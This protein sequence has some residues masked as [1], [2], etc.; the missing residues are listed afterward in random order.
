M[1]SS[2]RVYGEKTSREIL[3]ETTR[4][5]STPRETQ[6]SWEEQGK[7]NHQEKERQPP[8]DAKK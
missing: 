3:W 1:V 4:R 2:W 5:Q 7:E 6:K 8:C